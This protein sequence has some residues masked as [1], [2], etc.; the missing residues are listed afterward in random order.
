VQLGHFDRTGGGNASWNS[1]HASRGCSQPKLVSTG[2]AGLLDCFAANQAE[3]VDVLGLAMAD[4]GR[5]GAFAVADEFHAAAVDC[6]R[7]V[8]RGFIKSEGLR[9]FDSHKHG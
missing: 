8:P 2:G 5:C 4:V 3:A 9:R 6:C 7:R 1:A